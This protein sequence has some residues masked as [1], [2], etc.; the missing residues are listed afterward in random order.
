M[1]PPALIGLAAA[2]AWFLMFLCVQIASLRAGAGGARSLLLPYSGSIAGLIVTVA[3]VMG[4]SEATALAL[5]MGLLTS[6]S[7]FVLYVPALYTVLTSLSV[8]TM[9]W[10]ARSGGRLSE[11]ELYGHFAGR[12]AF[13]PRVRTLIESGYLVRDDAH[14]RPTSRGLAVARPFAAVKA[15]WRLGPGG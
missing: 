10:L 2:A 6:I 12:S 7:L 4:M 8:Q 5:A 13:E 9:I 1:W 3:A 11:A 15:F 14:Y